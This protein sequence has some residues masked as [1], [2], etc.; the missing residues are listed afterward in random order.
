MV[1]PDVL[2]AVLDGLR[3]AALPAAAGELAASGVPV[4]PCAPGGKAPVTRRGFLD[5]TTD[6]GRVAAWWRRMPEAN[7]GIPTGTAS[8]LVVVDV[9]VHGVNGFDAFARA[10]RAGPLA[11]PLAVVRTPTG[12]QHSYFLAGRGVQRS[13]QAGAAG[14][15]FRGDGGYIVAPPS[16]R[17]M[18]EDRVPYR[19]ERVSARSA[20]RVDADRLRDFLAPRPQVRP[21]RAGERADRGDAARLA[22][23]LGGQ[24]SDRNLKLFWAS[25]RLAEA[26]V[27]VAVALGAMVAVAQPDF[28]EREITRTVH[29]AY[30]SAH[31]AGGTPAATPRPRREA[32]ARRGSTAQATAMRGLP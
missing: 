25:C 7:I 16:V 29:S 14:V 26:G 30:R 6:P 27:P 4:F 23:W 31:A 2:A 17:L 12:G 13:W 24:T 3:G 19:V 1:A 20:G 18:G 11:A 22:A 32:P 10:A 28:G 5:A 9:D 15:D 21:R 8:G